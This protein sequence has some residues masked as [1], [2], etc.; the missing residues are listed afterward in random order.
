MLFR[1]G[2]ILRPASLIPLWQRSHWDDRNKDFS[3][4]LRDA[5]ISLVKPTDKEFSAAILDYKT[6][7]S[8][9]TYKLLIGGLA[10]QAGCLLILQTSKK[11]IF[12]WNEEKLFNR[13]Y[14]LFQA[15]TKRCPSRIGKRLNSLLKGR[16]VI[17][18]SCYI[19]FIVEV[20]Q[21][22]TLKFPDQI[23]PSAAWGG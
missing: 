4:H 2:E 19:S 22:A 16:V 9:Q 8:H 10:G 23:Y 15:S 20:E 7:V 11:I 14:S 21:D 12:S 13:W 3:I 6:V 18:H 1:R 5:S 17:A